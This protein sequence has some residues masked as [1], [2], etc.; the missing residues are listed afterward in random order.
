MGIVKYELCNLITHTEALKFWLFTHCVMNIAIALSGLDC[1]LC[2]CSFCHMMTWRC[3]KRCL[4]YFPTISHTCISCVIWFMLS[5]AIKLLSLL[6]SLSILTISTISDIFAPIINNEDKHS[7][8]Q[9]KWLGCQF[10]TKALS[11][12]CTGPWF[13]IKMSSYQYR[14]S[15]C[16]DK[17]VVRWSYLHNGNSYTGKMSSLYWIGALYI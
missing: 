10:D 12:K 11:Y 1:T 15:H 7:D 8:K 14:K 17:T 2:F 5:M 16:G 4:L 6:L 13:N 9:W 3:I